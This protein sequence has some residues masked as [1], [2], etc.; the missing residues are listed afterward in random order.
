MLLRSG[1]KLGSFY[2]EARRL[3]K[4]TREE[5][6]AVLNEVDAAEG[7]VTCAATSE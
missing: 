3:S 2:E 6:A 5:R 7:P 1:G 4:L